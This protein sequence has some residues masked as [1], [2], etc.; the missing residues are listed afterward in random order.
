MESNPASS[1]IEFLDTQLVLENQNWSENTRD[2]FDVIKFTILRWGDYSELSGWASGH[3]KSLYK[4]MQDGQCQTGSGRFYG[5]ALE[6]SNT[7]ASRG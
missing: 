1:R 2:F 6:T 5:V 4:G 3:H 7:G